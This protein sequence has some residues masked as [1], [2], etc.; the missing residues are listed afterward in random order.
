MA[1][2]TT[3]TSHDETGTA[4]HTIRQGAVPS[5]DPS[6]SVIVRIWTGGT[7]GWFDPDGPSDP[8][9]IVTHPR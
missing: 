8:A 2:C 3:I 7:H 6:T 9:V 5:A 1:Y 4:R